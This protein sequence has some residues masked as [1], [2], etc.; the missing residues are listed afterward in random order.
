MGSNGEINAVPR[1]NTKWATFHHCPHPIR[2]SCLSHGIHAYPCG[3]FPKT[4]GKAH[5]HRTTPNTSFVDDWWLKLTCVWW[6][7]YIGSFLPVPWNMMEHHTAEKP[8]TNK[9]FPT[10][11]NMSCLWFRNFAGLLIIFIVR[12]CQP[13]DG[14][15]GQFREKPEKF[16]GK[17]LV[18]S[19]FSEPIRQNNLSTRKTSETSSQLC[20]APLRPPKHCHCGTAGVPPLGSSR[21][22]RFFA[23]QGC[24]GNIPYPK[25]GTSMVGYQQ[26]LRIRQETPNPRTSCR[27]RG[28]K[29]SNE[30]CSVVHPGTK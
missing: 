30:P 4:L 3:V 16:M 19:R 28:F 21:L 2:V 5:T 18:S 7:T 15:K 8:R 12:T 27:T 14:F 1:K 29:C 24:C 6:T 17:A 25:D 26:Q 20:F 11:H 22:A 13:M 23:F 10:N 9:S